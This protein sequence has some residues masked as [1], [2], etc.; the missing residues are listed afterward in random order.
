MLLPK[1]SYSDIQLATNDF[2]AENLVGKGGFGSEY[3]GVF[4]T[5]ENGV[6]DPHFSRAPPL[7][8]R[9]SLLFVEN[10]VFRKVGVTTYFILF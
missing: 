3:E 6:V 7:D 5:G 8:R 4:R 9:D 2:S 10:F 1:I